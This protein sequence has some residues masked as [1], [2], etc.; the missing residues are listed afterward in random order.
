MELKKVCI[1]GGG[2]L[3]L[4]CAGVFARQGREVSILTGHP[5][6]WSRYVEVTD[7]DGKTFSGNLTAVSADPSIVSGADMVLFCLPGYLIED[8]MLKIKP[9]L[10]PR[11]LVGSIVAS[12]GFFFIAH[13]V[14]DSAQPLFAFQRT[15][16]IARQEEYGRRGLLLGY[17]SSLN[18]AMENVQ[19]VET[20]RKELERMF[21]TPVKLLDNFF[22]ASLTNSNPILHTGRLYSM[23]ADGYEPQ[24]EPIRFYAD[25]TDK[26]SELLI[27]MDS[28][29]QKL[30]RKM[31]IRPEAIPTL[32]DYYESADAKALTRKIASIA[33][34]K[35][36]VAPMKQT[37]QGWVP[38]FKSR[39]FTEDFPY[40]LTYIQRLARD[41]GVPAPVIDRVLAWGLSRIN[42]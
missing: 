16:Y 41:Y 15:P 39:Y 11:V 37:P 23:W 28:E 5:D 32:L 9:W 18:V 3:G 40:G 10:E 25:W 14:L 6:R 29:F 42:D 30:L 7:P 20:A 26:A 22:E 17:K 27:A 13:E 35:T 24:A 1:C 34:F 38:D 12:T 8:M 21:M 2:S 36:I 33:A 31:N 4:V 19:N